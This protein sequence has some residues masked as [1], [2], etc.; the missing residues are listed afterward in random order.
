MIYTLYFHANSNCV[1]NES[2]FLISSCGFNNA[3]YSTRMIQ[4]LVPLYILFKNLM[5]IKS[6]GSQTIGDG[7]I[8]LKNILFSPLTSVQFGKAH[9]Y[10]RP[11]DFLI[12]NLKTQ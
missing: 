12:F 7:M 11:E 9:R 5:C 10:Q 3:M 1:R 4:F 2:L 6:S 8:D